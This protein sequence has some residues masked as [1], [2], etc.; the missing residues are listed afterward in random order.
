MPTDDHPSRSRGESFASLR[1][2]TY[3]TL[4]TI[5][6]FGFLATQSQVIARG[7]LANDLSGSN[8]G[9]GGVFMAFG[10][11]MLV[12]TPLAGVAADRYS[13]RLILL[14]TFT[15]LVCSS[16]WIAVAVSFDFVEYWMLLATSAIQA[17]SFSFLVPARMALTGE[18]VGRDLI[19]NAIIL[20]QMSINSARVV[21]PAMAGVFIGVSWIGVAGVYYV[22]AALST[23]AVAGCFGLPPGRPA[24]GRP[25][26]SV[27]SE[28][29]DALRYVWRLRPIGLLLIVSFSVVMIG[30]PFL[31]FLPRFASDDLDVGA[32]GYGFLAAASAVGAV[33][34]S[35]FIAGR[36]KGRA[37]WRIQSVT[38]LAFGLGLVV[39]A[40]APTYVAAVVAV[41]GVGAA[42]AGFQAMNNSLVLALS[43]LEYHGRVQSL[44]MLSFSGFGMAALPLGVLADA[45]G[46]RE[47]I[48]IMG[49]VVVVAMGSYLFV[50]ERHRQRAGGDA[51]I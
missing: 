45:I 51:A 18:V 1:I 19:P 20:G 13:K 38:G 27:R 16:L 50:A 28:F 37:A 9:L 41:T 12:A 7:W 44:M 17:L 46:L 24:P 48:A 23:M 42:S 34:L 47:T 2:S 14:V 5:G 29:T 22:S 3:R 8:A 39:L 21:G 10:L 26:A 40:I 43:D 15:M 49:T 31:A 4:F 25:A 30:F 11:P 36:S 33:A 6:A 35:M 32:A